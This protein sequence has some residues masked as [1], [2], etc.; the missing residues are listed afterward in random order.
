MGAIAQILDE[1]EPPAEAVVDADQLQAVVARLALEASDLGL[2]L[3]DIAGTIQDTAAQSSEHASLLSRLTQAAEAIAEANADIARSLGETDKLA[4]SARK[5]LGE[6]AQQL[7][8]SVVAIDHMVTASQEIGQEIK[9]FSTALADV[10]RLADAIGTIARQTNLLALNAA[11]EAARAGDAGKGFA[12]VAAEVR[13]LSLQTS[14]TTASIQSTLEQLGARIDALVAA[15]DQ[16]RVSAEGVKSTATEVQGSFKGVEDVMSQ[17]LDSASSL[18]GTTEAVDRQCNEFAGSIAAAAAAILKSND[19]LQDTSG[20]V[21]EVVA[22]SERIIQATASAGTETPDTPYIRAA[23][24]VAAEV[25]AAFEAAVRSGRIDMAALFDRQYQPIRGSEPV[26]YM[27]RFTELTDAILP[28]IQEKAA[29]S[30]DRVAFCAC[31]DENG[32]LPTHNRKFSHSQRPGDVEWNTANC[33]NRRMFNDRVGL[34]AGRNTEP[35]LL[36]TYRRDM[37]GGQF[38]LMKDISAPIFVNGRHW[39]GLRLAIRV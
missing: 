32:Y 5:V 17:I 37:G 10:G 6:Q 24:S 34:A 38:V 3:V 23:M 26:Q 11:I 30:D 39:G 31:V 12:V 36:Q 14:Q 19:K 20:R 21:G 2:H 8:G 27:T 16:A 25:S 22:I 29:A 18:A 28:P 4:A 35:F 13:A 9:S 33:R 7:T 1:N 15:G